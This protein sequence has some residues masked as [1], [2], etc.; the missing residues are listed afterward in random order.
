MISSQS[1]SVS[2]TEKTTESVKKDPWKNCRDE[3]THTLEV[4]S[5]PLTLVPKVCPSL[6]E[7]EC[8]NKKETNIVTESLSF[9]KRVASFMQWCEE[10]RQAKRKRELMQSKEK[11]GRNSSLG[12]PSSSLCYS[13]SFISW[14]IF[15]PFTSGTKDGKRTWTDRTNCLP[16]CSCQSFIQNYMTMWS[17]LCVFTLSKDHWDMK[18]ENQRVTLLSL[19]FENS[20][21]K[22]DTS[23]GDSASSS[24]FRCCFAFLCN[25]LCP[26][27]PTFLSLFLCPLSWSYCESLSFVLSLH[28]EE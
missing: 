6:E 19:F 17:L 14:W 11:R 27:S 22:E 28:G 20:S 10:A 26:F 1:C 5:L 9:D 4:S 3:Q 25:S 12:C 21:W 15:F 7:D 24:L 13:T 23:A 2:V 8:G 16:F 18:L